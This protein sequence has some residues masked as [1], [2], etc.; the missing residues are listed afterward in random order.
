MCSLVNRTAFIALALLLAASS[1]CVALRPQVQGSGMP[2]SETRSVGAFSAIEVGSAIALDVTIGPEW[3]VEI[4]TDDN[5]VPHVQTRVWNDRLTISTDVGMTT[6]LGVH[7]KVTT[8]L[9]TALTGSGASV[10]CT[11]RASSGSPGAGYSTS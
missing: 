9:L 1:G 2:M 8:P 5:L 7:V 10:A 4:T 3:N 11:R 6:S